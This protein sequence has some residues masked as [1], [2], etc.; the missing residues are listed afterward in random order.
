MTTRLWINTAMGD[1]VMLIIV[2]HILQTTPVEFFIFQV[3]FN[4]SNG[5]MFWKNQ[6]I[7]VQTGAVNI[8][9]FFKS[10]TSF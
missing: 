5:K 2:I 8:L 6:T 3:I 4:N 1:V 7:P 9:L 10:M